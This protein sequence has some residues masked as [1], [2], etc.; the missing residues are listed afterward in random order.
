MARGERHGIS[1]PALT[2]AQRPPCPGD[3]GRVPFPEPEGRFG[4]EIKGFSSL[5]RIAA[6]LAFGTLQEAF[7]QIVGNRPATSLCERLGLRHLVRESSGC[8]DLRWALSTLGKEYAAERERGD[9][10]RGTG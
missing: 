5:R 7:R 3:R 9:A 8:I 1:R 2:D 4:E 10:K 6:V